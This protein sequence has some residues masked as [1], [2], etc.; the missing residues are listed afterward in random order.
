L[1]RAVRLVAP[2]PSLRS[3]YNGK[4]NVSSVVRTS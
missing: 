2:P 3:T 1:Q 4:V